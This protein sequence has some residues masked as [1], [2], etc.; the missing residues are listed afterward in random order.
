MTFDRR[1]KRDYNSAVEQQHVGDNGAATATATAAATASS[2]TLFPPE[3]K[4][5]CC[6]GL[7]CVCMCVCERAPSVCV[8][9]VLF[10]FVLATSLIL[11]KRFTAGVIAEAPL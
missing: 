2:S 5:Y 11:K 4:Y 8:C 7:L 9:I 1:H 10:L 3:M 6:R